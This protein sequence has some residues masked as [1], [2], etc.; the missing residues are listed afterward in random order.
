MVKSPKSQ[1]NQRGHGPEYKADGSPLNDSISDLEIEK[2]LKFCSDSGI[3]L[4]TIHGDVTY[5]FV[6]TN[7]YICPEHSAKASCKVDKKAK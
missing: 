1:K 6:T 2:I 7:I 4:H 5:H 3:P